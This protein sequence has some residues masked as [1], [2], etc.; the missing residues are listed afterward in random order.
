MQ[1]NQIV[2]TIAC[3]A[4]TLGLIGLFGCAGQSAPP[5]QGYDRAAASET[6]PITTPEPVSKE[7]EHLH[8]QLQQAMQA[9]GQTG[10]AAKRVHPTALR[11]Q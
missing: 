2:Q 9:P 1:L 11:A 7:H 3:V 8:A 6:A 4:I 10:A 5:D